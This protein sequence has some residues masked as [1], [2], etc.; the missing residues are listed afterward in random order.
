[1]V[2]GSF[3]IRVPTSHFYQSDVESACPTL[4]DTK[5]LVACRETTS[6]ILRLLAAA[7]ASDVFKQTS[8]N[9]THS[10]NGTSWYSSPGQSFGFAREGDS[11]YLNS[12]DTNTSGANDQRLSWHMDQPFGGWR[13]GATTSLNDS[14]GFERLIFRSDGEVV[15][16]SPD[17]PLAQALDVFHGEQMSGS[18]FL[19]VEDT[20]VGPIVRE[21][22][23][24]SWALRVKEVITRETA[25]KNQVPLEGLYR[26]RE[27]SC[28]V[29]PRT[30]LGVG[31]KSAAYTFVTPYY[32]P[33]KPIITQT[34]AGDGQIRLVF[35]V[36][37]DGGASIS[38][39]EAVCSDGEAVYMAQSTE[40]DITLYD[41]PN[42][43][44][45]SCE[46]T[47]T[48]AIGTSITSDATRPLTPEGMPLGLPIWLLY[49]ASQQ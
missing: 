8:G 43:V 38:S 30:A 4:P 6:D 22:V 47:A 44:A 45:Y 39:Y 34:S 13:C 31:D 1:M 48:N 40:P 19:N 2:A 14:N 32:E 16:E 42:D 33:D 25:Y 17:S 5:F 26:G 27:Y 10:V 35:T 7:P 24:N 15:G 49:E 46:V 41:L 37:D 21:G 18:W 9:T 3:V 28:T 11:V 36:D 12:A 29:A 20:D 23:L